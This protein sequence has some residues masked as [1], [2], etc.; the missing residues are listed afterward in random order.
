MAQF[1]KMLS[2]SSSET[3]RLSSSLVSPRVLRSIAA[4]ASSDGILS[5][6]LANATIAVAATDPGSALSTAEAELAAAVGGLSRLRRIN[7]DRVR[8]AIR[9]GEL[10]G[11]DASPEAAPRLP[12]SS[13]AAAAAAHPLRLLEAA[14]RPLGSLASI[15]LRGQ[16]SMASDAAW[17]QVLRSA[18][19]RAGASV[20]ASSGAKRAGGWSSL[21]RG[22]GRSGAAGGSREEGEGQGA[23]E[24]EGQQPSTEEAASTISADEEVTRLARLA[25]LVLVSPDAAEGESPDGGDGSGGGGPAAAA[26]GAPR[27]QEG[28]ETVRWVELDLSDVSGSRYRDPEQVA[29]AAQEA[30]GTFAGA[31][32]KARKLDTRRRNAADRQRARALAAAGKKESDSKG[33]GGK[34][35]AKAAAAKAKEGA[36]GKK[37]GAK[38]KASEIQPPPEPPMA[39]EP[40]SDEVAASAAAAAAAGVLGSNPATSSAHHFRSDGL[41]DLGLRMI[42]LLCPYLQRLSLKMCEPPVVPLV[43]PDFGTAGTSS[44]VASGDGGG[45]ASGGKCDEWSSSAL[46]LPGE[47]DLVV[48]ARTASLRAIEAAR[49]RAGKKGKKGKGG[50]KGKSGGSGG[51]KKGKKKGDG[52]ATAAPQSRRLGPGFA[53]LLARA[54]GAARR[55]PLRAPLSGR[56]LGM[57]LEGPCSSTL[58]ELDLGGCCW[59]GKEALAAVGSRCSALQRLR[60]AGCAGV[61]DGALLALCGNLHAGLSQRLEE[62]DLTRTRCSASGMRAVVGRLHG[63][64]RIVLIGCD[65]VDPAEIIALARGLPPSVQV[66]WRPAGAAAVAGPRALA[67]DAAGALE[68]A[69]SRGGGA[70]GGGA[71]TATFATA[72]AQYVEGFKAP[73]AGERFEDTLAEHLRTQGKAAKKKKKK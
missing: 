4:N 56:G 15:S 46:D 20:E 29:A 34:K 48:G 27:L 21:A 72:R 49:A 43:T 69:A 71:G 47:E 39:P 30:V 70:D 73:A 2:A 51:G 61:D 24:G 68:D 42:G 13:A 18:A 55:V 7:L 26:D 65:R 11:S 63:L 58:R 14:G 19:V 17:A 52:P 1:D 9:R 41:T 44:A 25:R 59:V 3:V 53:E 31:I 37:K 32:D 62:L 8:V 10:D 22:S 66:V 23:G 6:D 50:A 16:R 40:L 36:K 60:L 57:L 38:K 33:K 12:S 5:L 67:G 35:G 28:A 54:E 45:P 64:R